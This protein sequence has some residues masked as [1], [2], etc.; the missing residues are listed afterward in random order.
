[1]LGDFFSSLRMEIS[2]IGSLKALDA[3]GPRSA[4]SLN[5][6]YLA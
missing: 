3:S 5:A 4:L 1:M 2:N 6:A